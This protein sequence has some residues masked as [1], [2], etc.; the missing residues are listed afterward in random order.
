MIHAPDARK[1]RAI[2]FE[3]LLANARFPVGNIGS[4]PRRER[5]PAERALVQA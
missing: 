2:A 4:A 5:L 1:D 3:K